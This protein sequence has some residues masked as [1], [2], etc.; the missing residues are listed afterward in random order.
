MIADPVLAWMVGLTI[1][2]V[3][4]LGCDWLRTIEEDW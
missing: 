2:G 1:I 4:V 3:Y